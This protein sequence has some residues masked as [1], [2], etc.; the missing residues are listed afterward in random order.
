M[1]LKKRDTLSKQ[2]KISTIT[3]EEE[4]EMQH[5][6]S[7][8]QDKVKK[9]LLSQRVTKNKFKEMMN[10]N[11]DGLKL[12]NTSIWKVLRMVLNKIWKV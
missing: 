9:I 12:K 1:C 5:D 6:I 7:K 4:E 2:P 11:M 8:L 3:H 10:V